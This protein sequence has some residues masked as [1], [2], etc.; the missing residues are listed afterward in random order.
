MLLNS[1]NSQFLESIPDSAERVRF[2]LAAYNVGLGHVKD[3]QQ[4]AEKYG[5]NPTTLQRYLALHTEIQG[6]MA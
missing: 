1:L 2:V 6:W 4:L 3:A 5:K